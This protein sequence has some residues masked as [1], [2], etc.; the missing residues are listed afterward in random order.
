[1]FH[2]RFP[3]TTPHAISRATADAS[4]TTL[5]A[6]AAVPTATA[7]RRWPRPCAPDARAPV[8]AAAAIAAARS[9]DDPAGSRPTAAA[10]PA[11]GPE[12]SPGCVS[13][14]GR[15]GSP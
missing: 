13:P 11:S 9:P 1:M 8:A 10:W 15:A 2:I 4:A 12:R 14:P 7:P 3:V 6:P 5:P